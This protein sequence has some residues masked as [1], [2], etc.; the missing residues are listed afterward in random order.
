MMSWRAMA[1]LALGIALLSGDATAQDR[2]RELI[3]QTYT[4]FE[5]NATVST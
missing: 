5:E 2:L 3:L 1:S 4:E